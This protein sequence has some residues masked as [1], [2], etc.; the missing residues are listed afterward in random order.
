M[1]EAAVATEIAVKACKRLR[2]GVGKA[3][4]LEE[5]LEAPEV[6]RLPTGGGAAAAAPARAPPV[7]AR[8][9]RAPEGPGG[10]VAPEAPPGA[11]PARA[12]PAPGFLTAAA[13]SS[14]S[15]SRAASLAASTKS[16]SSCAKSSPVRRR[17]KGGVKVAERTERG[18]CA[19]WRGTG[20]AVGL[21]DGAAG[22]GTLIDCAGLGDGA[23]RG[24]GA[25]GWRG[26]GDT[27]DGDAGAGAAHTGNS[28]M[29]R[30]CSGGNM[31][32]GDAGAGGARTGGSPVR[33]RCEGCSGGGDAGAPGRG[34]NDGRGG[35]CKGSRGDGNAGVTGRRASRDAGSGRRCGTEFEAAEP[36]GETGVQRPRCATAGATP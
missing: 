31:G 24:D 23:G 2:K 34:A 5:L 3:L 32:D 33:R 6:A 9:E 27:G 8:A 7:P 20:G 36:A 11:P 17:W 19:G 21:G 18:N 10:E 16:M 15:R 29:R 35:R 26:G 28:S 30:R 1:A 4:M 12:E 14:N 22:S 25:A 13:R